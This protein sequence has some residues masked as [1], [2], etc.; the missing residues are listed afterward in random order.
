MGRVDRKVP[1]AI[2][3]FGER[4]FHETGALAVEVLRIKA[5]TLRKY[6][7]RL[8]GIVY[9]VAVINRDRTRV[10]FFDAGGMLHLG[11]NMSADLYKKVRRASRLIARF[12]QPPE[13]TAEELRMEATEELRSMLARALK[14][15]SR[16]LARG[17][18]TFPPLFVSRAEHQDRYALG[19]VF[20]NESVVVEETAIRGAWRDGL[21]YRVAALLHVSPQAREAPWTHLWANALAY[22]LLKGEQKRAW[23][24]VWAKTLE[25]TPAWPFMLHLIEH[26]QT[27]EGTGFRSLLGVVEDP[28]HVQTWEQFATVLKVIHESIELSMGTEAYAQFME[29]YDL[30]RRPKSLVQRPI[31]LPEFHL[32][33]RAI[34]NPSPMGLRLSECRPEDAEAEWLRV[35]YLEGSEPRVLVIGISEEGARVRSLEYALRLDD[36][37]PKSGGVLA[38]GRRL[39]RWAMDRLGVDTERASPVTGRIEFRESFLAT[40]ER[41][42]LERLCEGD[43]IILR[44]SL[45]G[46]PERIKTLMETGNLLLLPSF[47]HIGIRPDFLLV[48][49]GDA[50]RKIVADSAVESTVLVTDECAYAV[51][52]APSV[53]GRMLLERCT[54]RGV[55]VYP[56]VSTSSKHELVRCEVLLPSRPSTVEELIS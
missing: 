37:V 39:L 8:R 23:L 56:I 27:Y 55:A 29:F 36:I 21:V 50:I 25:G 49:D 24:R 52:S 28:E 16:V 26:S 12:E 11:E 41:A 30:L 45:I 17:E 19:V 54:L 15:V 38:H 48:G 43:P 13:P 34:P 47:N 4:Q 42:V 7:G 31:A 18:P 6:F 5:S 32:R 53:W 10:Y 51:V 1:S 14:R 22:S 2:A 40:P 9:L 20:E 46:S 35:N 44:N 33:P 3:E